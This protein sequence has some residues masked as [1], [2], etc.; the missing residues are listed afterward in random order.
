[1]GGWR[2]RRLIERLGLE[3]PLLLAPMAGAGGAA[4]AIGAM[5]GGAVGALPCAIVPAATATAQAAEVRTACSGPLNLNFFCH[6]DASPMDETRWH[7]LLQPYYREFGVGPPSEPLPLR[8]AFGLAACELVE[9]VKPEIV[10]FHFGL[11]G[12]ALLA[13]VRATGALILSSATTLA[14]GQWL[15]ARGV[16]AVIAQGW[17][18]GGHSARFLEA[19]PSSRLT[20]FALVPLLAGALGLPIIAAGG[21]GDAGAI[22]AAAMLGAAGV[23]IGTSF[24]A[25]PESLVS[26]QHRALLG[27]GAETVMTNLFSGRPARG[28]ATRLTRELGAIRNEV[29]VFPHAGTALAELRRANP[30]G[31]ANMWAG[32]AAALARAEPAEAVARRLI[33]ES[34]CLLAA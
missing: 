32:Q 5:R 27:T 24:L 19:D 11:P 8:A 9:A 2:D 33:L 10:S 20:T 30:E 28:F 26:P 23:Q 4:L 22:A 13:R 31:F 25:C 3:T 16:D 34:R 12:A 15:A 7:A 21:I 29:P 14:E 18:A 6:D 1:M 17:E